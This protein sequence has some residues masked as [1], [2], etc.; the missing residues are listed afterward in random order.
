[1]RPLFVHDNRMF[2][3]RSSIALQILFSGFPMR[4][5]SQEAALQ[6][7]CADRALKFSLPFICPPFYF[8]DTFFPL[9]ST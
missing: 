7:I 8:K 6:G 2:A 5:R 3:E 9:Q 1:M 4:P